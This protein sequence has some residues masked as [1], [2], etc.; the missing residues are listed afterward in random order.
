MKKL[1]NVTVFLLTVIFVSGCSGGK[2]FYLTDADVIENP[3]IA[4][5]PPK[6]DWYLYGDKNWTILHEGTSSEDAAIQ[7]IGLSNA[8]PSIMTLR[9]STDNY[10]SSEDDYYLNSDF[11]ENYGRYFTEPDFLKTNRIQGI[12]FEEIWT[13]YIKG[14]HC[15]AGSYLQGI[16]GSYAPTGSKTTSI[17]CGYYDKTISENDGMRMLSIRYTI[18]FYASTSDEQKI[19]NEHYLKN[20]V[21]QIVQSIQIK[22]LDVERMEAEGLMF[23]GNQFELTP[24]DSFIWHKDDN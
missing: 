19:E 16:G 12:T 9:I 17:K 24:K 4:F 13:T 1:I 10:I 15:S 18:N 23:Y 2:Y 22:N 3:Y 21:N 5:N 7:W 6:Q 14:L 11:D 8:N 20:A